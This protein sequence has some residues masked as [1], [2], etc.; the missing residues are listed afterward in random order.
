MAH[1]SPK[2]YIIKQDLIKLINDEVLT[3]GQMVPS[4]T[5]L[6]QQ[7]NVSRITARKALDE[8]SNEGYLYKV[9]GKG[10]F[11]KNNFG[12]QSLSKICGYTEE[13]ARLGM[14]VSRKVLT[15]EIIPCF[16][17]RSHELQI[18][19]E[20]K[21]YMLKR[22]YYA[23][24]EPLC[25][26]TAYLPY[27]YFQSIEQYDF[28]LQSLYNIIENKYIYKI[29]RSKLNLEAVSADE[30]TCLHLNIKK[31]TPLIL[32]RSV[33]YGLVKNQEIPI[34]YFKT[35]YLTNK[36]HYTLEQQR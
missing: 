22:I 12:T 18:P 21:L 10:C 1:S 3:A 35:Y 4:E 8:L 23:D 17:K 2:Y 11:V 36:I 20:S 5:K 28:S 9:Q 15:A 30:D 26:T 29:T 14:K 13:I 33:T 31:G 34:E 27:Q 6:M 7:Y 32:F 19:A 24:E 25:L 16:S